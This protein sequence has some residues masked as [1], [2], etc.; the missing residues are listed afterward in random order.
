MTI[1]FVKIVIETQLVLSNFCIEAVILTYSNSSKTQYSIN[2]IF[3]KPCCY[4]GSMY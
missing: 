3:E 2:S 4:I 1:L